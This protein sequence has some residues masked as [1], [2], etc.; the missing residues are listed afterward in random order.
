[1]YFEGSGQ[2][3]GWKGASTTVGEMASKVNLV[4]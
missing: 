1:M 2:E 3:S 4:N